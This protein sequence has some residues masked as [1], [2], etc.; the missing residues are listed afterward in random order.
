MEN[1]MKPYY[2]HGSEK[3]PLF[4]LIRLAAWL[5]GL[6]RRAISPCALPAHLRRDIGLDRISQFDPR[7]GC[8]EARP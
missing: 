2:T 6:L 3:S 4:R 7:A 1:V 5:T 8:P